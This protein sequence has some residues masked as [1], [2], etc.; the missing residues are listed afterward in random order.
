M[1]R[2]VKICIL[3]L[4]INDLYIENNHCTVVYKLCLKIKLT[5]ITK[6]FFVM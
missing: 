5:D 2:S 3:L 6:M 4:K 1:T